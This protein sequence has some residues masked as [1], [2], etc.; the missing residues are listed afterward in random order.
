MLL[1][2]FSCLL[3]ICI[4]LEKCQL[5]LLPIFWLGSFFSDINPLSVSIV[6]SHSKGCL[7][8]LF[9]VS[10]A[11]QKLLCLIRSHLFIFDFISSVLEG[12]SKRILLWFMSQS[13]VPMFSSKGFIVSGLIF[14]SVIHSEFIF[15]HNIFLSQSSVDG[16]LNWLFPCLGYCK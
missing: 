8:I 12:G 3:V 16:H 1:S 5:G 7:L 4:S 6:F 9:I 2:I 10:F 13:V 11:V 15:A 14:K